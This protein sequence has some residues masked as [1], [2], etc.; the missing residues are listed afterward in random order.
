MHIRHLFKHTFDAPRI[1][2]DRELPVVMS[3]HDHYFICPTIHLLDDRGRYCAGECTPG[4]GICPT[5]RAGSIPV[6]KHAFVY[7]WREDVEAALAGVAAFVTSSEYS[8]AIH[9]RILNVTRQRPF[10]VIEHGRDLAQYRGLATQPRPGG[11]VRILVPGHLDRHKG[12]DLIAAMHEL[13]HAGRLAFH[14]L[15]DVPKRYRDLGVMHGAYERESLAAYVRQIQPSFVG[16]FSA[17]GESYSHAMTEAWAAG[18]PVLATDLGAQA[19]RVRLHGGGFVISHD[20]AA[21]AL[22]QVLEAADDTHAYLREAARA[23]ADDL[24]SVSEMAARYRAL[25]RDV[26]ERRRTLSGLTAAGPS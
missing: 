17:T 14:F 12:A 18:V 20:D 3:F 21:L 2:R 6:L 25:Y 9:R 1:A 26:L 7:Q 8:R 15:G 5:V 19:E 24:A 11:P 4:P 22:S 13:D 16:V 23:S 10:E